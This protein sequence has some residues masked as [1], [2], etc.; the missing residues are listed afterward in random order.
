[1]KFTFV[2]ACGRKKNGKSSFSLEFIKAGCKFPHNVTLQKYSPLFKR[3]S[4]AAGMSRADLV[5][6]STER[7]IAS[8]I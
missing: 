7:F 1:M 3:S 4:A 8:H 2:W 6:R 5:L